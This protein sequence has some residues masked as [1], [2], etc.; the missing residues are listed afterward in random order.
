MFFDSIAVILP[1]IFFALAIWFLLLSGLLLIQ[2]VFIK[3]IIREDPVEMKL[4]GIFYGVAN[5]ILI[6]LSM[7]F[8]VCLIAGALAVPLLMRFYSSYAE[9]DP[10]KYDA[11]QT[12]IHGTART[13]RAAIT[14]KVPNDYGTIQEALSAASNGDTVVVQD[15]TYSGGGNRN[16][17]FKGKAITLR[18]ENGPENCI[19]DCESKGRGFFFHSGETSKSVLDGFTVTD[20]YVTGSDFESFGAGIFCVGG[21]SP[22]IVNCVITNN[23]ADYGAGINCWYSAPSINDCS[24]V[25]NSAVKEGGAIYCSKS[26]PVIKNCIIDDNSSMRRGGGIHCTNGSSPT[27]FNCAVA[28]CTSKDDGGAIHCSESSPVIKNCVI[29]DNS[30]MRS[31]GGIHCTNGSSPTIFNC[32]VAN[33]TSKDDGGGIYCW[34]SSPDIDSCTISGNTAA[35]KGGGVACYSSSPTIRN[36]IVWDNSSSIGSELYLGFNSS[37]SVAHTNIS[38]ATP[39]VNVDSDCVLTPGSG[40]IDANPFFVS[41]SKGDY[42]LSQ[43]GSGQANDSPCLN[44]GSGTAAEFGLDSYTT[45]TDHASDAGTVDLGYHYY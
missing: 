20:G 17:D 45:R 30:S 26:S 13:D 4:S 2:R 9:S 38:L 29:D 24:L 34:F 15:G 8:A 28:N 1:L 37:A 10:G 31:G 40:I 23:R 6:C 42:Y 11:A 19:I 5:M 27:I 21:S 14:I 43:I 39:K 44:A 7:T 16:L 18:S 3:V 32:V 35:A 22:T 12:R 36:S 41:G 25:G 33:C